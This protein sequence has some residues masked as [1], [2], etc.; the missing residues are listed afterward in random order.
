MW[1]ESKK[2]RRDSRFQLIN[3]EEMVEIENLY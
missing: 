3:A 2:E 1:L